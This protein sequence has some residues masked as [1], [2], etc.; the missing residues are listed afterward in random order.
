METV[1]LEI[2]IRINLKNHQPSS[3]SRL[4]INRSSRTRDQISNLVR[5]VRIGNA[6]DL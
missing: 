2:G 6:I 4:G 1:R 3:V 5:T